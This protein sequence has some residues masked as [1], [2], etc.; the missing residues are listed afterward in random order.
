MRGIQGSS[1]LL[2]TWR[3]I[4]LIHAERNVD[5]EQGHTDSWEE[6]CT[7]RRS[8]QSECMG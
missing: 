1:D 8:G 2:G 4:E 7:I 5:Y 3:G 6:A